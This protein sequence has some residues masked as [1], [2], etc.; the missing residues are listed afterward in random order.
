MRV[1]EETV[2]F[3]AD[4]LRLEGEIAVP[5]GAR[6]GAVICHPHPQY[7]GT[8]DNNVVLAAAEALQAANVAT[9]RFNFR[10]AGGSEGE[11]ASGEGEA[12]DARAA[13]DFLQEQSG[14]TDLTLA[15]YSFGAIVALFAGREADKA[16]RIVGVAAPVSMFD[17]SF[18]NGC[19]KPK[20]FIVGDRDQFCPRNA[21]ERYIE[22]LCEPKDLVCLRGADHFFSGREAEVADAVVAFVTREDKI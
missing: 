4:G 16:S 11:Y 10:G 21:L 17:M 20:L 18:L 5:S 15:G 9:L 7:G 14:I 8:M 19:R 22:R 1:I 12:R 13:V 2:R 3:T 6:Y